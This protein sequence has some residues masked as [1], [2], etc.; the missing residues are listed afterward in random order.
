MISRSSLLS[1][2]FHP[3]DSNIRLQ[4][5]RTFVRPGVVG[6]F[7]PVTDTKGKGYTHY[8]RGELRPEPVSPDTDPKRVDWLLVF[9]VEELD[10][11][12]T[13]R[14]NFY[15]NTRI[16]NNLGAY[17]LEKDKAEFRK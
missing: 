11:A 9:T 15:D 10:W 3:I 5:Y 12:L 2:G 1:R 16:L 14:L 6:Y 17:D 13:N 8:W 7:T 4:E